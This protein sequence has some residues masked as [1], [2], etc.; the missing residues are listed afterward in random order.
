MQVWIELERKKTCEAT[1]NYDPQ[2]NQKH[3]Q[4]VSSTQKNVQ[5]LNTLSVSNANVHISWPKL[6]S[7]SPENVIP[8]HDLLSKKLIFFKKLGPI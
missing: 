4:R 6:C 2:Q 5:F 1:Q 3:K 8:F 7:E